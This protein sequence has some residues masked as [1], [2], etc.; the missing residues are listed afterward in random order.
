MKKI[1]YLLFIISILSLKTTFT[2]STY[3]NQIY[4][5][6]N[7]YDCK[8]LWNQWQQVFNYCLNE[9]GKDIHYLDADWDGIACEKEQKNHDTAQIIVIIISLLT[10]YIILKHLKEHFKDDPLVYS[11]KFLMISSVVYW[12]LSVLIESWI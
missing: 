7:Y 8:D 5:D 4:C 1:I 3:L 2:H 12:L 9:I 6:D 10:P 11:L